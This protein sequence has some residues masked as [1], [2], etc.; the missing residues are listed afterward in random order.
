[1]L[2]DSHETANH[3][4]HVIQY[5]RVVGS[6]CNKFLVAECKVQY[7]NTGE[8][9]LVTLRCASYYAKS[10]NCMVYS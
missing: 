8:R 4:M 9:A 7:T 1:M 6:V 3:V 2:T 10:V 5:M